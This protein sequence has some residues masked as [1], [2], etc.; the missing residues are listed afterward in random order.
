MARISETKK[1]AYEKIVLF[2]KN[3]L[4]EDKEIIFNRK[5]LVL[6]AQKYFFSLLLTML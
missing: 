2:F 3:L 6:I 4:N 5:I 1:Y